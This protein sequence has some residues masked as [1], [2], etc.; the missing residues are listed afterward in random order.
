MD[1]G[2]C[3]ICFDERAP[4]EAMRGTVMAELVRPCKCNE[5]VHRGCLQTWRDTK[6]STAGGGRVDACDVCCAKFCVHEEGASLARVGA[7]AVNAAV[8]TARF[9]AP[10]ILQ[11]GFFLS[12]FCAVAIHFV[13]KEDPAPL[14][15]LSFWQLSLVGALAPI[16][17]IKFLI[18]VTVRSLG[19]Q[20]RLRL[21]IAYAPLPDAARKLVQQNPDLSQLVCTLILRYNFG[22]DVEQHVNFGVGLLVVFVTAL[23]FFNAHLQARSTTLIDRDAM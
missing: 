1:K 8:Q 13:A 2:A 12:C 7:A 9:M 22:A 10:L 19:D 17:G 16:V 20:C 14:R 3:R 15:G 6:A 18:E 11:V 4:T 5:A 23:G 21:L